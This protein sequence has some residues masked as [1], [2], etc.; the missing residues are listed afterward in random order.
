MA[1]DHDKF[2]GDADASGRMAAFSTEAGTR[3]H[4]LMAFSILVIAPV[5]ILYLFTQK[6][7]CERGKQ[8]RTERIKRKERG[9]ER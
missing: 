2:R 3:Y 5:I 1:S 7:N 4:I 9:K 6:Y 8:I